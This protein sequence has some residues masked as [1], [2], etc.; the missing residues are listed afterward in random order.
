MPAVALACQGFKVRS[1]AELRQHP[2]PTSAIDFVVSAKSNRTDFQPRANHVL[3]RL[4]EQD[5]QQ[6]VQAPPQGA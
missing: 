4:A 2:R 3:R 5:A 6:Q 1:A